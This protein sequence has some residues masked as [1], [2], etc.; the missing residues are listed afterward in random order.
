MLTPNYYLRT[1]EKKGP[2]VQVAQSGHAD[3][4]TSSPHR[5]DISTGSL[6]EQ[7]DVFPGTVK[8][9]LFLPTETLKNQSF[10]SLACSKIR[11]C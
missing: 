4:K 6:K 5:K 3:F 11:V 8:W 10:E 9:L 2:K 1:A 7:K